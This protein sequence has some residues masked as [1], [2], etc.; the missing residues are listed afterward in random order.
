MQLSPNFSLAEFTR[1]DAAERLGLK[2]D[3]NAQQLANLRVL[4]NALQVLRCSLNA[5]ILINSGLRVAAVNKAV[6]GVADSDHQLGYAA[7]IRAPGFG[8]VQQ[9][10]NAIVRSGL[11]FDQLIYEQDGTAEWVHLSVNPRMRQQVLS[12]RRGKGYVNGVVKL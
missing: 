1:S 7:D 4:A 9:L 8:T 5:P 10:A 3:P 2:N 12:W 11:K 6:G